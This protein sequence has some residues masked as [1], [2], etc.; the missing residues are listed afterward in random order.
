MIMLTFSK[1]AT[2][3]KRRN[4]LAWDKCKC[5]WDR[6][7]RWRRPNP[8][9][10]L[11]KRTAS[12]TAVRMN[13]YCYLLKSFK[14]PNS[15]STYI[16]FTVNNKRRLRQHN[17]ETSAGAKRTE[18]G[19]P[20]KHV[21]IVSGFP[22]K[23]VA[24]QFEWQ[25]QHPS[26]SRITRNSL[27]VNPNKRGVKTKLDVLYCLLQTKL[28]GQLNLRLNFFIEDSFT[29]FTKTLKTSNY[30]SKCTLCESIEDIPFLASMEDKENMKNE[31]CILCHNQLVDYAW[32]CNSCST[33]FHIVCVAA[34]ST[35]ISRCII[36]EEA[37]CPLCKKCHLWPDIVKFSFR[38]E[39]SNVNDA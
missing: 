4:S 32:Q 20:W 31:Q 18:K 19:R 33:S 2:C 6:A 1:W 35:D 17:G 24:L 16:G 36:P 14:S 22:N 9:F 37:K 15:T 26:E 23:N 13:Y 12:C 28:W 7:S 38:L 3:H 8:F 25:W 27:T 5:T 39:S 29:Y 30:I 10:W 21:V 34:H 11:N